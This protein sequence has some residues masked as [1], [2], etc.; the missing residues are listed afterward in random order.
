MNKFNHNFTL[1]EATSVSRIYQS[2]DNITRIDF[3]SDSCI[4]VA[5]YKENCTILPTFSVSPDNNLLPKGRDRL[6]LD[7]FS[8]TA[9][10]FTETETGESFRLD[11]GVSINLD[12]HNFILSYQAGDK[13]LFSDRKPLAYN[14]N[15]EFGRESYHYITREK[16]E[17]IY[18]LGDKSGPLN[19]SGRSYR[20]ECSDAMGYDAA[21]SDPL[22]KHL[23]FYICENSVGTYG[24]FYDTSDTSFADFGREINNYYPTYKHFRTEDDCLVYYVFFGSILSILRQFCSLCGKQPLPPEWSFDYCGSTMAYTDAPDL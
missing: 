17:K 1:K 5:M 2:E 19:K 22:Y 10:K 7:G 12:L 23:P 9:P 16:D 18:G 3:I 24:I 11:C 13:V 6:S 4:R 20:I 15:G 14:I 21:Q 8:L